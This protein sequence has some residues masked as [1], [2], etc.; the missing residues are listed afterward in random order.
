MA[1]TTKTETSIEI[2]ESKVQELADEYISNLDYP[3]SI[4]GANKSMFTGMVKYIYINLFKDSPLDNNNI[5]SIDK[6]WDIYT[7]LCYKYGKRP[8]LLNFSLLIGITNDTFTRWKDGTFRAEGG[9]LGSLHSRTVKKWIAECESTLLDGA[10]EN[11]FGCIFALKANYG[12]TEAPQQ[13]QIVGQDQ[14]K[15]IEQ[16]A[17]EHAVAGIVD[18]QNYPELP[19]AEL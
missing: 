9:E 10:I 18:A 14:H 2:Y 8:T 5:Q 15:S 11:N 6:V 19:D 4:N 12:Y 16:I 3:E 7:G 1:N 17:A 13:I